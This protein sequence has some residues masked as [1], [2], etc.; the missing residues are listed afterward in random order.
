MMQGCI[1]ETL[2]VRDL[3]APSR[4]AWRRTGWFLGRG[5]LVSASRMSAARTGP[6]YNWLESGDR[7][8]RGVPI[9]D[10]G[11]YP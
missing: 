2:R 9:P 5:R 11:A 6:R 7:G 1:L 3:L 10:V 4:E 8:S